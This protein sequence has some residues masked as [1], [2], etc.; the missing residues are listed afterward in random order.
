[1]TVKQLN[2]DTSYVRRDGGVD[3]TQ[4]RPLLGDSVVGIPYGVLT[5]LATAKL[6]EVSLG[7]VTLTSSELARI[8]D[9]E[10]PLCVYGEA[11][12]DLREVDHLMDGN[13]PYGCHAC[14]E[15]Y[16]CGAMECERGD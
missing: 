16:A 9:D 11:G 6:A 12:H 4:R 1:M 15:C 8:G 2:V 14:L 7:G 13:N 5:G 10:P 3:V